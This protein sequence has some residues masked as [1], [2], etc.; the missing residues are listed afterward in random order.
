[1]TANPYS[2]VRLRTRVCLGVILSGLVTVGIAQDVPIIQRDS[3][4]VAI[5]LS[6]NAAEIGLYRVSYFFFQR[7]L[8]SW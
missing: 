2:S 5:S 6:H 3:G 7:P 4:E 1:L 8:V